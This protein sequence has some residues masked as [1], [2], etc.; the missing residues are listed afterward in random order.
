MNENLK[1]CFEC[2]NIFFALHYTLIQ[3]QSFFLSSQTL[4]IL[5]E[6]NC[7]FRFEYFYLSPVFFKE[8][9]VVFLSKHILQLIK[10]SEGCGQRVFPSILVLFAAF[11]YLQLLILMLLSFKVL[12]LLLLLHKQNV[13]ERSLL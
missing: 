6:F 8:K 12:L 7:F 5:F 4:F 1:R 9:K 13:L 10:M 2:S 3:N 11:C